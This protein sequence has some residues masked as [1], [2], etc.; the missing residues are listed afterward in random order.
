MHIDEEGSILRQAGPIYLRP[1]TLLPVTG[2]MEFD[3][4]DL[5]RMEVDGTL[6]NVILHEMGHVIGIGTLWARM[7][8]IRNSGRANPLFIGQNAMREFAT[9][10]GVEGVTPVPIEN[11]GG[12]GTREGHWREQVFG[13]ELM[14]GFL[15]GVTQPFSRMTI[16]SL[17][18]MGYDVNYGA[19][20]SYTIPTALQLALMGIGAEGDHVVRCTMCAR[21]VLQ[22]EPVVLPEEA[23][24]EGAEA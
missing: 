20:D 2:I 6:Q 9:L 11:R 12:P 19:A 17:E 18:D 24:V 5:T 15:D 4:G 13:N 21:W 10:L 1:G 8:L 23:M 14:T 3:T 16:A 22:T 7:G